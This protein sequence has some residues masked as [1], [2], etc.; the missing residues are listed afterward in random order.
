MK[1]AWVILVLLWCAAGHAEER[2]GTA[3]DLM[4]RALER[5]R[6]SATNA[7]YQ[8]AVQ[9]LKHACEQ[10][11]GLGDAWYFRSLFERKL[12][13]ARQADYALSKARQ[14]G[15]EALSQGL[16]PFQMGA[17]PQPGEKFTSTARDKWALVI[18]CRR[19]RDPR[20]NPLHYTTA[21]AEGFAAVLKDPAA[22]RFKPDH[23]LLLVDENATTVRIRTELNKLAHTAGPGDLVVI[24]IASHGSAREQDIGGVN[25]IITYDTNV[26]DPDTLYA[27]ALPMWE[28]VD[29]VRSRMQARKAAVFLDTCHSAGAFH[30]GPLVA[31]G[32]NTALS[33]ATMDTAREGVGR[34]IVSSSQVGES[35]WESDKI[36]HGYFTYYLMQALRQG[37]GLDPIGKI[38]GYL[39]EQVPKQV[40]LDKK[41]TQTP[42][43]IRS[44]MGADL[45]VGAAPPM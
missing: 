20:I 38:Y 39:R 33:A 31:L 27:T 19:F 1:T 32:L 24:F 10:C 3:R 9:L 4:L 15:S 25:Y 11:A 41:A 2:C 40:M 22:G 34:A 43:M 18:G 37:G 35:S 8:D 17:P 21:D 29:A 7:D 30:S 42:V 36:Q 14:V 12:G 23:V 45:V 44:E 5:I 26:A 16:N 6:A 28:V 13:N